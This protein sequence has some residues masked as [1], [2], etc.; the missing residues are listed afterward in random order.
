MLILPE[1]KTTYLDIPLEK[2]VVDVYNC[3]F[4]VTS[5]VEHRRK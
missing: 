4:S 5:T 1:N 2:H 3:S